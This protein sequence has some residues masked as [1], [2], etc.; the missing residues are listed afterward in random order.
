MAMN[1]R[2]ELTSIGKGERPHLH[3]AL[4]A[5][6]TSVIIFQLGTHIAAST[7]WMRR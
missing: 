3:R 7:K 1:S 6:W 4:S 2:L 5:E